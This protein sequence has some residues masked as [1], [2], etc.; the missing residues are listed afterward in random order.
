VGVPAELRLAVFD[1]KGVVGKD[2]AEAQRILQA[3]G[4]RVRI[5]SVDGVS[6]PVTAD[7]R[8]DRVNLDVVKGKVV[9]AHIG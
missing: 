5:T 6:F 4:Y 7:H 3:K 2:L 1:P 9:A 8:P